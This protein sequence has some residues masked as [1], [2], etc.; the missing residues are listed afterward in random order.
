MS[1]GKRGNRK[2]SRKKE[3]QVKDSWHILE[4]QRGCRGNKKVVG[5][6]KALSGWKQIM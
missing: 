2:H 6:V 5:K 3:P 4:Q 1:K